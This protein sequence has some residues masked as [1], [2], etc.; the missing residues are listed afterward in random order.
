MAGMRRLKQMLDGTPLPRLDIE[1]M[2]AMFP[3]I[4][5]ELLEIKG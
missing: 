4:W 2:G 3:R 1:Q 5:L